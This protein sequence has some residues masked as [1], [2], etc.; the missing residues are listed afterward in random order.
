MS[1]GAATRSRPSGSA[2]RNR[3]SGD[4]SETRRAEKLVE[5]WTAR[6]TS[7]ASRALARTRE[8]AEDVWA[9]AKALR[10]SDR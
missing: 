2:Q 8:E 4:Q 5:D 1:G 6:A 3:A 7:W 9:E 10:R